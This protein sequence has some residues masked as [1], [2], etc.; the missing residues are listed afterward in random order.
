MN[1]SLSGKKALVTGG[2]RGIGRAVALTLAR[3][4]ADVTVCHLTENEAALTLARELKDVPGDH[5]VVRVDVRDRDQVRKLVEDCRTRGG[6]DVVVN[7]AGV[8]SHVPFGDLGEDEWHRI[9]DTHLTGAFLVTQL[10]LPLLGPGS[11]VVNIG[12]RA[13]MV[14]IPTRSHY[15]AAKAG[16]TGLSRSLCKELG[17]RGVRVNVVDPGVIETEAASAMPPERYARLRERYEELTSLGRLGEPDEVADVVLF[18]ASDLSRYVT[19][20]SIPV[21]GGI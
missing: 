20:A 16:L 18:L 1:A 14:G 4:G 2:S 11:S 9:I 7:N 6:L 5:R 21:D 8:I 12:S 13:A 15:T 19:G 17:G 10:A 3:A